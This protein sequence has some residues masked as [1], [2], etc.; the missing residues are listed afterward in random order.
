M[1]ACVCVN[2]NKF[3]MWIEAIEFGAHQPHLRTKKSPRNNWFSQYSQKKNECLW[4]IMDEKWGHFLYILFWTKHSKRTKKKPKTTFIIIA[5]KKH[6]S[7]DSHHD[8]RDKSMSRWRGSSLLAF[9]SWLRHWVR[10]EVL[11]STNFASFFCL[12]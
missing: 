10:W 9:I 5:L 8:Y 6:N 3:E 4:C 12:F 7:L 11:S 1:Y 2:T